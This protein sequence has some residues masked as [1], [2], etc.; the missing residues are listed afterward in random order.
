[1]QI[2]VNLLMIIYVKE[3]NNCIISRKHS[4]TKSISFIEKQLQA[5]ARGTFYW[6]S[7]VKRCRRKF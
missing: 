1:M 6:R 4:T 3:T 5:N 7:I 2:S